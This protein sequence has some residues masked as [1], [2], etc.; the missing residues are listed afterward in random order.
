MRKL[1]SADI[2]AL[3]TLAHDP[4]PAARQQLVGAV[5][6]FMFRD[7]GELSARERE[8]AVDILRTLIRE[9]ETAIRRALADRL[10][11][12]PTAPHELIVA[13]ANDEIDVAQ[14]VLS[15]SVVL[16]DPDLLE[17]IKQRT[18]QHQLAI[19]L[20]RG[21]SERVSAALVATGNESVMQS[22]LDNATARFDRSVL[23]A[24]V[25]RSR[26]IERIRRPLLSREE[27]DSRLASKMYSWV[28]AA[29]RRHI[30]YHY[31]VDADIVD[32]AMGDTIT[33]IRHDQ[34]RHNALADVADKIMQIFQGAA[35]DDPR[36]LLRVLRAGEVALFEGLFAKF[37]G[38]SLRLARRAIY[39]PG[40]KPLAIV[41][42]A[43]GV[44]KPNFASLF[45]LARQARPGDKSVDPQELPT[46]L[47]FFDGL[48]RLSAK[49]LVAKWR[50]ERT[51]VHRSDFG[52]SLH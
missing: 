7:D 18:L 25:E 29:L 26:T 36:L 11:R 5:S 31:D 46:V 44:D 49:Q 45:L 23:E 13:L 4:T 12:E 8:I 9:T 19:A 28:S 40:G 33:E 32:R 30:L 41:C 10:S 37:T 17:V 50:E 38:L 2:E 15:D 42:R 51:P 16:T 34:S 1:A 27:L 35:L 14:P 52:R 47:N 21:L 48:S 22:V 3:L 39:E 6:D 20:R 43:A 24:M